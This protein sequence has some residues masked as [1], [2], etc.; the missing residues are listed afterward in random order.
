[1]MT[2]L[3]YG[4]G[5]DDDDGKHLIWRGSDIAISH[6]HP[7]HNKL[8]I[9]TVVALDIASQFFFSSNVRYSILHHYTVLYFTPTRLR[10]NPKK[11]PKKFCKLPSSV[12]DVLF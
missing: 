9:K 12:F 3:M 8:C 6:G 1:M 5:D 4:G 2:M 10:Q 7:G 11:T